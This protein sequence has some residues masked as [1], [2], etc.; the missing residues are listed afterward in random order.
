MQKLDPNERA[1]MAAVLGVSNAG[2]DSTFLGRD[3]EWPAEKVAQYYH[4]NKDRGISV[5]SAVYAFGSGFFESQEMADM[6]VD[7]ANSWFKTLKTEK[8]V[9]STR[10][11]AFLNAIRAKS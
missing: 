3:P 9:K 7:E 6:F 5:E 11:D 4:E 2:M 1:V 8:D 10:Y